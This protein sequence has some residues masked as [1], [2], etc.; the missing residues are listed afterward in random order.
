MRSLNRNK[1]VW[2]SLMRLAGAGIGVVGPGEA[3][4]TFPHPV[5][6]DPGPVVQLAVRV[7][8][9]KARGLRVALALKAQTVIPQG[10]P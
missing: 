9:F 7:R 2:K 10:G 5:I 8:A 1:R 3:A 6:K 4:P